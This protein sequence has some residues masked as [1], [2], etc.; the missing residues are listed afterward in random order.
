MLEEG[1]TLETAVLVEAADENSGVAWENDWIWRHYGRFRKK[2]V[3][4]LVAGDRRFDAIQ[5]EL[6]DHTEKTLYFDITGFFGK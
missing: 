4:V 6:A 5:V 1:T 3:N 2:Q